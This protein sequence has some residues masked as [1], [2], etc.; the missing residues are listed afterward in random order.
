MQEHCRG[1]A[2]GTTS[3]RGIPLQHIPTTDCLSCSPHGHRQERRFD[4]TFAQHAPQ[5]RTTVPRCKEHNTTV[6]P[7]DRA[8]KRG[9]ISLAQVGADTQHNRSGLVVCTAGG[10]PAHVEP[11][12]AA[13]I[14]R[15]LPAIYRPIQTATQ[16]S[17]GAGPHADAGTDAVCMRASGCQIPCSTHRG[18]E[19]R[20][21]RRQPKVSLETET[22]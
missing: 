4:S 19:H 6:G 5:T 17:G 12:T 10:R 8:A 2:H 16:H 9:L 7:G 14:R 21:A 22:A 20:L 18:L 15:P 11:C 3:F 13:D 1:S